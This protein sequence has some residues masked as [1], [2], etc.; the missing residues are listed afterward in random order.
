MS[1]NSTLRI[2]QRLKVW[3]KRYASFASAKTS[4]RVKSGDS[5]SVIARKFKVKV[6]DLTKWNQ[7]NKRSVIRPGQTLTIYQ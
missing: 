3:P 5:L 7:L 2:G 4:Y 6:S 1:K